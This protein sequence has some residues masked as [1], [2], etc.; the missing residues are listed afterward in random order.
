M[1]TPSPPRPQ[2]DQRQPTQG[3][4]GAPEQRRP[5]FSFWYLVLG[6]ALVLLVLWSLQ[7][8]G[9]EQIKYGAFRRL[10]LEGRVR[11]VVVS[12]DSIRGELGDAGPDAGSTR[13]VTDRV[14]DDEEL[15]SLLQEKLGDDWDFQQSWLDHPLFLWILPLALILIAWRFILGRMNPV[16]SV[17]N[18]SQSRASVVA[19]RDVDVT[20]DD[21]AGIE[22]CKQELQEV[23]EFLQHPSKFTRLGGRIPKGVLLVGPPGTGKTLLARAVAG[24]A[25]VTF[26]SL[27]G[28]DFVEM[29]VGVGAARVRDL[30]EQAQKTAPCII[31]IDELDALGK[32]RGTGIMGGHDEREQTLNALLVQMDGFKGQKGIIL[33]AATNRPEMLDPALLRPGRFD[34]QIVV[35]VPDLKDR[36]EILHVHTRNVKLGD[37]VDLDKLAAMTPGF[38]GADL[39]NLVNEATLLAARRD[40]NEVHMEDFEDS[41]ERVVAGLEKRNRLMNKAEKNTVAHHEAGHALAACL[42]PGADPVRKVSMIPRGAAALGYTMQ[43]PTEDRY[44]LKKGE[45]LDRM[46][47]MLGGRTAEEIVFGEVSTGAHNDLQKATELAREMVT[48]YGMCDELGPISYTPDSPSHGAMPE[49]YF[50][51]PWSERTA[52]RIDDAV[53]GFIDEAHK[54]ATEQLTLHK[55]ALL[56]IAAVLK[57]KEGIEQQE[58][59][60]LLV[61][62]GIQPRA[63]EKALEEE[64]PGPSEATQAE[65]AASPADETT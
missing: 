33:L 55:D 19:Q 1:R 61:Q 10:L 45:L 23:I 49:F 26:F 22:E 64:E 36:N 51:K 16:S 47:V 52:R 27:S 46:A 6:V 40:K 41:I 53:R 5:A 50:G 7:S 42:L 48:R 38:V 58:L 43:M 29:F 13:F 30:F 32:A 3:P 56:A 37:S 24:E 12:T 28:S 21:V 62:H 44:V 11:N 20:F 65:P 9:R 31:F 8:G 63:R 60:E 54:R 18:F 35:P 34:R 57:E 39:A 2:D 17:M 15:V 25:D 59:Q 4:P 14:P